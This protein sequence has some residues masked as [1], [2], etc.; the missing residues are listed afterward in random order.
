[1]SESD[2]NNLTVLFDEWREFVEQNQ[3]QMDGWYQSMFGADL[4]MG[5]F[6]EGLAQTPTL[7]NMFGFDKKLTRFM[8]AANELTRV[9]TELQSEMASN[10]MQ[11]YQSFTSQGDRGAATSLTAAIPSTSCEPRLITSSG[12]NWFPDSRFWRIMSASVPPVANS[13]TR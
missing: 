7:D 2:V 1:M 6:L 11:T 12:V 4:G 3:T 13:A 5:A 8:A 10:W 9:T